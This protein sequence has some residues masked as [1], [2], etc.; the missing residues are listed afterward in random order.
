M[1]ISASGGGSINIFYKQI[2]N[3]GTI[4]ANGGSSIYG[5]AGN[6]GWAGGNGSISIGNISS[7][8]YI[9]E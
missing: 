3:R 7:N 5:E 2:L 4:T 8:S 1:E 9:A 6:A